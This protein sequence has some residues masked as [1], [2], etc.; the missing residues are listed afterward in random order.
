MPPTSDR[1]KQREEE[2]RKRRVAALKALRE[3][4]SG[5]SSVVPESTA[6]PAQTDA[7]MSTWNRG[8]NTFNIK[9]QQD[10]QRG[11]DPRFD[12][13][14]YGKPKKENQQD[15]GY[16]TIESP[17]LGTLAKTSPTYE[18]PA[19]DMTISQQYSWLPNYTPP[20][21]PKPAEPEPEPEQPTWRDN[22]VNW[23]DDKVG[24]TR[25]L[26]G[27]PREGYDPNEGLSELA[28][29]RPAPDRLGPEPLS[30]ALNPD[31]PDTVTIADPNIVEHHLLLNDYGDTNLIGDPNS[32]ATEY[33]YQRQEEYA[34]RPSYEEQYSLTGEESRL[35]RADE[36]YAQEKEDVPAVPI[37]GPVAATL[38]ATYLAATRGLAPET[39]RTLEEGFNSVLNL[40]MW[41]ANYV[42][43][44]PMGP[45]E[46][47]EDGTIA[48]TGHSIGEYAKA[49]VE[50]PAWTVVY[51]ETG[52]QAPR[53]APTRLSDPYA[54]PT[55]SGAQVVD[56]VTGKTVDVSTFG[57]LWQLP[58]FYMHTFQKSLDL[59]AEARGGDLSQMDQQQYDMATWA[60]MNSYSGP[61]AVAQTY[62]TLA[63]RPQMVQDMRVSAQQAMVQGNAMQ[64]SALNAEAERLET[65]TESAIVDEFSRPGPELLYSMVLD[66]LNL[67]DVYTGLVG[68]DAV[69]R[70]MAK[71]TAGAAGDVA[72][73]AK[74]AERAV[75][76][77]TKVMAKSGE[78]P[79]LQALE[80]AI[81]LSDN[82][83]AAVDEAAEVATAATRATGAV[84]DVV[85]VTAEATAYKSKAK[86]TWLRKVLDRAGVTLTPAARASLN[87]HALYNLGAATLTLAKNAEEA[88]AI[89]VA[90]SNDPRLLVKGL[91][92]PGAPLVN[93]FGG[94]IFS[95]DVLEAL[96]H[97]EGMA[98]T[99]DEWP[100]LAKQ[101]EEF[102][103]LEVLADYDD[104]TYS[105]TR[106]AEGFAESNIPL[107]TTEVRVSTPDAQTGKARV[108]YFDAEGNMLGQ[109]D[110]LSFGEA[111]K[112]LEELGE[113][114]QK[115]LGKKRN[116][117]KAMADVT[118]ETMTVVYLHSRPSHWIRNAVSAASHIMVDGSTSFNTIDSV[119]GDMMRWG[120]GAVPNRRI[121]EAYQDFLKNAAAVSEGAAG[122]LGKPRDYKP[123]YL[124]GKWNYMVDA[125]GVPRWQSTR[126]TLR[127][128]PGEELM[129][130]HAYHVP[131]KRALSQTWEQ[132]VAEIL[133]PNLTQAGVQRDVSRY[134]VDALVDAGIYG[135]K[136][137]VLATVSNM[138][139]GQMQYN[140][141]RSHGITEEIL[142][143]DTYAALDQTL[144]HL[145]DG[146]ITPEQA[147]AFTRQIID[148]ELGKELTRYASAPLPP[149]QRSYVSMD[150]ATDLNGIGDSIESIAVQN[151]VP[152]DQARAK[153]REVVDGM[154]DNFGSQGPEARGYADLLAQIDD[155][156]AIVAQQR[157]VISEA[158][159]QTSQIKARARKAVDQA[160]ADARKAVKAGED[161][162]VV[163]GTNYPAAVKKIWDD[164]YV[165]IGEVFADA[166]AHIVDPSYTPKV[167]NLPADMDSFIT[168]VVKRI[169]EVQKV[170]GGNRATTQARIDAARDFVDYHAAR[171]HSAVSRH[172]VSAD[173]VVALVDAEKHIALDG[174][175]TRQRTNAMRE[176]AARYLDI[177]DDKTP[178]P[179]GEFE[180][181][182]AA[183]KAAKKEYD[184]L[185]K[186][187]DKEWREWAYGA[188]A[189]WQSIT[190]GVLERAAATGAMSADEAVAMAQEMHDI[191]RYAPRARVST[192]QMPNTRYVPK[193]LEAGQVPT[194]QQVLDAANYAG[195]P[196]QT[197]TTTFRDGVYESSHGLDLPIINH[198]NRHH[199]E[200]QIENLAQLTDDETTL[201]YYELMERGQLNQSRRPNPQAGYAQPIGPEPAPLPSSEPSV[202]NTTP[203]QYEGYTITA[204]PD[205]DPEVGD[206]VRTIYGDGEIIRELKPAKNSARRVVV[207]YED[208]TTRTVQGVAIGN[209]IQETPPAA[210]VPPPAAA[211]AAAAPEAATAQE[212]G[213][214]LSG[215]GK[216]IGDSLRDYFRRAVE[217]TGTVP[218]GE[219]KS[220]VG[221][222]HG[223]LVASGMDPVEAIEETFRVI[224]EYGYTVDDLNRAWA[225]RG[226][227]AAPPPAA[228]VPPPAAAA[229]AADAAAPAPARP[230]RRERLRTSEPL[231]DDQ[232]V[233][234][235]SVEPDPETGVVVWPGPETVPDDVTDPWQDLVSGYQQGTV[236]SRFGLDEPTDLRE[237]HRSIE[238]S[239]SATHNVGQMTVGEITEA[240]IDGY[241][242]AVQAMDEIIDDI[243]SGSIP[244]RMSEEA[245]A[246]LRN[247]EMRRVLLGAYDN[248]LKGA[249]KAAENV[250]DFTMLNYARRRGIDSLLSMFVPYHYWYTRSA[251]NWLERFAARP[252]LVSNFARANDAIEQDRLQR[253]RPERLSGQI[254]IPEQA[255]GMDLPWASD[256]WDYYIQNPI[257]YILPFGELYA[258]KGYGNPERASGL[259]G[260]VVET[261]NLFGFGLLPQYDAAYKMSQGQG[262]TVQAADYFWPYRALGEV[263]QASGHGDVLPQTGFFSPFDEFNQYRV[264]RAVSQLQIEGGMPESF[265][266]FNNDEQTAI[267]QFAQQIA[268]NIEGGEDRYKDIPEEFREPAEELYDTASRRVGADRSITQGTRFATGLGVTRYAES[269]D[270]AREVQRDYREGGYS[271]YTNDVGSK[272][273]R[274]EILDKYPWLAGWW[275]RVSSPDDVDDPQHRSPAESGQTTLYWSYEVELWEQESKEI[276]D[277]ILENLGTTEL[278]SENI[279]EI[280]EKYRPLHEENQAKWPLARVEGSDTPRKGMNPWEEAS[281]VVEDIVFGAQPG[282]RP[283][284]PEDDWSEAEKDARYA[285]IGEWYEDW[286][287]NIGAALAPYVVPVDD[288]MYVAATDE[289]VRNMI[290]GHY[291][292]DIL[293][294]YDNNYEHKSGP[295]IG[296]QEQKELQQETNSQYWEARDALYN[297]I[298]AEAT[299]LYGSDVMSAVDTYPR[300]GSREQKNAWKEQVGPETAEGVYSYFGWSRERKEE[301]GLTNPEGTKPRPPMAEPWPDTIG[302]PRPLGT[303][304]QPLGGV[305]REEY[306]ANNQYEPLI[307]VAE[308]NRLIDSRTGIPVDEAGRL[309]LDPR[310]PTN[311]LTN[312]W[313]DDPLAGQFH[314]PVPGYNSPAPVTPQEQPAIQPFLEDEEFWAGLQ[315]SAYA[316]TTSGGTYEQAGGGGGGGWGR[317]GGGGG[318]G[319]GGGGVP[320]QRWMPR[321]I[322]M[323]G[324]RNQYRFDD[325]DRRWDDILRLANRLSR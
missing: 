34:N 320:Q 82:A 98:A 86:K 247:P 193:P 52:Q 310:D 289:A 51:P 138:L 209:L 190:Q 290:T 97:L 115:V 173:D 259:V 302:Q 90:M 84:D 154:K 171:A 10:V 94:M 109:T 188:A 112:V 163:W 217:A 241:T 72:V 22:M 50:L 57:G 59:T 170:L 149:A 43:S 231:P 137:Q 180:A 197:G 186:E 125:D 141:L 11:Y 271:E 121:A 48:P 118:R 5:G 321:R 155:N 191:S 307:G 256:K 204:G 269:E 318:W 164:A 77:I 172:G 198:W 124:R 19:R 300:G 215:M 166:S 306:L 3:S 280:R 246:V 62:N 148:E 183:K 216:G 27:I 20:T 73:Q 314:V 42:E 23:F 240:R 142:M 127:F 205:P 153:A 89:L 229:P 55:D 236:T 160:R 225:E 292:G 132:S 80:E 268:Y 323:E 120:N 2:E 288:P 61:E 30:E 248:A 176:R 65:M 128:I 79:W 298:E 234:P 6:T 70:R 146:T 207:K 60:M 304:D 69:S 75:D 47:L 245:V 4:T 303:N 83:L 122:N 237:V 174:A 116:W 58:S 178:V 255:F 46:K 15:Q 267:V 189:Y 249:T 49:F 206:R 284:Y 258:A 35:E 218:A 187:I 324:A 185:M 278:N 282:E 1:Q 28:E 25:E 239:R 233:L 135:D 12:D 161:R 291:V 134:I 276:T 16:G 305:T 96:P 165:E 223:R 107:Q 228:A 211:A 251:A 316:D 250:A 151:G 201:L 88:R 184:K 192:G 182:Q 117:F 252:E 113:D 199:P 179:M 39:A 301:L 319:G 40:A 253:D 222:Y 196:T 265:S 325:A 54:R 68:L 104:F 287:T 266:V 243:V 33:Y 133:L 144:R 24:D 14:D 226:A 273:T 17:T 110:P 224:D 36:V 220:L 157:G 31:Y 311:G 7:A 167:T 67:I 309:T 210:A 87:N 322:Q 32:K 214:F 29:P 100:S 270:L 92:I 18:G 208:G 8:N 102:S 123:W 131:Y 194:K 168:D 195:L 147:K 312:D 158:Y 175:A 260:N 143:P 64:A 297:Q 212:L 308:E 235:A 105:A 26:F 315:A 41:P 37:L 219:A 261:A 262:D 53:Y 244:T 202:V 227:R 294:N 296:W 264:R 285:E 76:E 9:Q 232:V 126:K 114:G 99:L 129:Y 78:G 103:A 293:R 156:P 101:G 91:N 286:H 274:I 81:D 74:A 279:Q 44:Q 213:E 159:A 63:N 150:S 145:S 230:S 162:A 45:L 169:D 106:R 140:G 13:P 130:A 242:R 71:G 56:P 272:T 93:Q 152:A 203:G 281:Y 313:T 263:M 283:E 299:Q 221:Q 108:Q 177:V 136:R 295:E 21:A 139:G 254:R 119:I 238:N 181:K 38:K 111:Q 257:N 200:K 317:G 275:S 85:E 95:D 277:F 66:P